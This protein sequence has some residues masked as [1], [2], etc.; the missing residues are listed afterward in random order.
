MNGY[1]NIMVYN[2]NIILFYLILYIN[3]QITNID[4]TIKKKYFI[5]I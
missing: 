2:N 1:N 5:A 4:H 3:T